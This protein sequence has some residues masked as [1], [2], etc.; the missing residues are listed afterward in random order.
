[1]RAGSRASSARRGPPARSNHPNI[2]AIY[3]VGQHEGVPYIV[4]ELL[5]GSSLR[6]AAAGGGPHPAA[7]R[8]RSRSRSPTAWPQPTP[9]AS[10]TATSSPRTSSSPRM[11][12]SRSST[13]GLPSCTSPTRRGVGTRSPDADRRDRGRCD[14]R[15]PGLHV[16][17]AAERQA[18]RPALRHLRLRLRCCSRCSPGSGPSAATPVPTWSRRSCA[19]TRRPSPRSS[20]RC[21]RRSSSWCGAASRSVRRTATQSVHDLA[22]ALRAI[23]NTS[24]WSAARPRPARA[25]NWRRLAGVA[26]RGRRWSS[27]HRSR[28]GAGGGRDDGPPSELAPTQCQS[29]PR[30]LAGSAP[31]HVAVLPFVAVGGDDRRRRARRGPGARARRG[32]GAARGAD[33]GP[34]V[35]GPGRLDP[36]A[37]AGATR[38][39]RQRRDRRQARTE[40]GRDRVELDAISVPGESVLASTV[41]DGGG[42][43]PA[44]LQLELVEAAA[45][46]AGGADRAADAGGTRG[47]CTSVDRAFV[48]RVTG[49][50]LMAG[51]EDGARRRARDRSP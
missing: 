39:Q 12:R 28:C 10:S 48:E 17:R 32:A 9:A 33:A 31:R 42:R 7:G 40:A 26:R 50:G 8:S 49:L 38:L 46:S 37:R 51:D 13:S 11:A 6:R 43:M 36:L 34:A 19:T 4:S 35:G 23:E 3:D 44:S 24:D 21:R 41:I 30:P 27:S 5:R 15:H 16:A 47:R 18:G 45:E 29:P 22:L 2:L 14:R 25:G 20:A 1:M